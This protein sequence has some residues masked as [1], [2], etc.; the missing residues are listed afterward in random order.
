VGGGMYAVEG[1]GVM[2]VDVTSTSP[3]P[4]PPQ[5]PTKSAYTYVI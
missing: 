5:H 3:T 4:L 1:K 2:G